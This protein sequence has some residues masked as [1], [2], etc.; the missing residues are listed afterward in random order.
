MYITNRFCANEGAPC[1]SSVNNN[2]HDR[3]KNNPPPD[4]T[5]NIVHVSDSFCES[6]FC[7]LTLTWG[8]KHFDEK[9][10][11]VKSHG[12]VKQKFESGWAMGTWGS[13]PVAAS[14]IKHAA[15]EKT[16]TSI[17]FTHIYSTKKS[18]LQDV[19]MVV[20]PSQS[21]HA[22]TIILHFAHGRSFY[23]HGGLKQSRSS[24]PAAWV[25]YQHHTKKLATWHKL[26]SNQRIFKMCV[27]KMAF[28]F[29]KNLHTYI[30]V[31]DV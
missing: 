31:K 29:I 4:L 18:S 24:L 28:L 16:V 19:I 30:Y 15:L 6:R 10:E 17:T 3:V 22:K 9:R 2:V 11:F 27:R 14:T 7:F 26:V 1:W 12:D 20:L 21:G 13:S 25:P 23:L 8:A 5:L